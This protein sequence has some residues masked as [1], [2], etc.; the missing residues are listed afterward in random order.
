MRPRTQNRPW[1]VIHDVQ[2]LPYLCDAAEA[3]LLL[4]QKPGNCLPFGKERKAAR[5]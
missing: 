5:G 2:E 3:G 1:W 4:R